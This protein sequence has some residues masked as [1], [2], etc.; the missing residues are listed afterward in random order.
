MRLPVEVNIYNILTF[1]EYFYCKHVSPPVLKS[2]ISSIRS[3]SSRFSIDSSPLNHFTVSRYLRSITINSAFS[4]TSRGIFDI[5]TLYQISIACDLLPD[6]ILYRAIFLV[7][8]EQYSPPHS[9][10]LFQK[11]KQIL[12][13]DVAFKPP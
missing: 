5:K 2:Y 12:R 1:L 8:D 10:K 11:D 6:P 3:K 9:A 13:K 7:V 4:P